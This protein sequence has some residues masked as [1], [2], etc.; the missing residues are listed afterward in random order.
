MYVSVC[1][2]HSLYGSY[3]YILNAYALRQIPTPTYYMLLYMCDQCVQ[4]MQ[5]NA[6]SC[7]LYA[8]PRVHIKC[9]YTSGLRNLKKVINEFCDKITVHVL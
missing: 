3:S 4:S 9:D 6:L 5:K 7:A 1:A 2:K 8:D